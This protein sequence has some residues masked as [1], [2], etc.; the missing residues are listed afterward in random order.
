MV[1]HNQEELSAARKSGMSESGTL[2]GKAIAVNRRE[3]LGQLNN[4]DF[5]ARI[6]E[7]DRGSPSPT[8]TSHSCW[9]GRTS[10]SVTH[11]AG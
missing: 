9:S 2:F 5:L 3:K 11:R 6:G 8:S 10:S 4:V 1:W 7:P